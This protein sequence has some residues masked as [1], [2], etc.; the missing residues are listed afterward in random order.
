[1]ETTLNPP[2]PVEA[3]RLSE[4]D[5]QAVEQDWPFLLSLLP[6]D[7]EQQAKTTGAFQ[8]KRGVPDAGAFLR[9][10]F[11]YAYC[12][13]SLR[14]TVFWAALKGIAD[15][16]EVALLKRLRHAKPWV[17]QL[18]T[19]KLA[20]TTR[21]PRPG[22]AGLRVR[23]VDATVASRPGS[24]GTDWRLHLGFDLATLTVDQVEVTS[25]QGG[26]TLKRLP[27]QPG[28]ITLA[29]R[30]YAQRQ[31]IAAL[32]A[33]GGH[34]IVRLNWSTVPLQHSDGRPFDLFA[35]LR[36]LA[37][38]QV[39]EWP[40]RTAPATDGTPAVPGR[41]VVLQKSPEAAEAARRKVQQEGRRK[42]KTP[43]ARTLE[44]AGY[45]L[46]FTTL[47]PEV[48]TAPEILELYRFRWQIEL[49]FKRMKSLLELDALPAKDPD[50]CQ[51]FLLTKLLA[52]VLVEELTHRWV[53]FSPWGYGRPAAPLALAGLSGGGGHPAPDDRPRPRA[54]RVAARHRPDTR[55]KGYAPPPSQSSGPGEE[56]A[57]V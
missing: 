29:D 47:P 35:A 27:A 6:P 49:A 50:L 3:T 48:L 43:D 44:A 25:A 32:T 16:S 24:T 9:L 2:E 7:W 57:P 54:R 11:A 33:Q 56:L 4:R 1:M 15:L 40:V 26:E 18:L 5:V 37:S 13:L 10:L 52:A 14:L 38:T 22:R 42:G 12:G 45:V 39:G 8:R 31:G 21:L 17:G 34:V 30:G 53:D 23:L 51:T 36:S 46:L 19:A 28:E 41:L 20:E 55:L